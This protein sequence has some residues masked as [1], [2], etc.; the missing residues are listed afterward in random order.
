MQ[1]EIPEIKSTKM[2]GNTISGVLHITHDSSIHKYSVHAWGRGYSWKHHWCMHT[3]RSQCAW[4]SIIW[5]LTLM[6]TTSFI[7]YY[8]IFLCM[9]Q[10][11]I[12]VLFRALILTWVSWESSNMHGILYWE[13]STVWSQALNEYIIYIITAWEGHSKG[14]SMVLSFDHCA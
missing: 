2:W 6:F 7:L 4:L 14:H 1:K 10:K 8:F 12:M 5:T 11:S 9:I 3:C 13:L